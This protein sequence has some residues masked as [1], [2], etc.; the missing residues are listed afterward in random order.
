MTEG[1]VSE[2][3][4]ECNRFGQ[5]LVEMKSPGYRPADLRDFKA[6]R[7][8]GSKQVAFMIDEN[9][10]FVLQS[11]ECGRVNDAVSIPLELRTP[12]WGWFVDST[13]AGAR[14][15]GGVGSAFSHSAGSRAHR[16][17]RSA[18]RQRSRTNH[19]WR[20]AK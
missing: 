15:I 9:L 20:E 5:V 17:V 1:C 7:Q 2:I 13:P 11:P 12:S 14:G 16:A 10:R 8:T 19:R 4:R 18:G 3:M 6:V